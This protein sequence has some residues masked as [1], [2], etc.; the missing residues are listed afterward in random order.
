MLHGVSYFIHNILI[1]QLQYFQEVSG[2]LSYNFKQLFYCRIHYVC[3]SHNIIYVSQSDFKYMLKMM[4]NF[5]AI[6][7]RN[8]M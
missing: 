2:T 5:Y 1:K 4:S 6:A 8:G 3:Y 7:E